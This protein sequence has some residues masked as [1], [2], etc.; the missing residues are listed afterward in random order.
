MLKWAVIG[1]AVV[2]GPASISVSW[3]VDPRTVQVDGRRVEALIDG[4]GAPTV[5]LE[6]GFTGGRLQWW[7]VHQRVSRYARVISYERAGL[8][9]SDPGPEPRDAEHIARELHDLLIASHLPP[10]YVL[11]GHSAGGLFVRVFAHRY[12]REVAGLVLVDPATEDYYERV[13]NGKSADDLRKMGA[14]PAAVAQWSALSA[15]LEQARDAWPLPPVPVV[16][17]T[18]GTPLKTWPLES[19]QDMAV[20]ARTHAELVERLPDAKHVVI[21]TANHLSILTNAMV[22]DEIGRMVEAA[23]TRASE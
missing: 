22:S 14:P 2:L 21:P 7:S 4:D 16:V 23:R 10:P 9:R 13:R 19:S 11:V 5:V 12:P 6:A 8:G 3:A 1:I 15:T 18:S 20:W 17:F